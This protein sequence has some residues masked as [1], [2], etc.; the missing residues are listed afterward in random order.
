MKGCARRFVLVKLTITG[1]RAACLRQQS[2]L[3]ERSRR[4][5]VDTNVNATHLE[6]GSTVDSP[7]GSLIG[8]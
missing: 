3:L 6:L 5:D 4:A 8:M 7:G 2:Y 1:I